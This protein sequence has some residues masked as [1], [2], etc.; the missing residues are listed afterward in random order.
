MPKGLNTESALNTKL[1]QVIF[2]KNYVLC[3]KFEKCKAN[4]AAN[5]ASHQPT[6]H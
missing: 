4:V 5:S 3:H 1:L 2:P 6:K